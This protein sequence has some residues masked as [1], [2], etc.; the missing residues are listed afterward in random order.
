MKLAPEGFGWCIISRLNV[1]NRNICPGFL[2]F[3]LTYAAFCYWQFV[4]LSGPNTGVPVAVV[5]V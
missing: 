1:K 5:P 3:D 2:A 4:T